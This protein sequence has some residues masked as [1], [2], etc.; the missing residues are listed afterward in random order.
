[1]KDRPGKSSVDLLLLS[2]RPH[3]GRYQFQGVEWGGGE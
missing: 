3:H 1:L 2:V